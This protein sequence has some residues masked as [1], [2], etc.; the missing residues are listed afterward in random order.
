M[1]YFLISGEASGDLHASNLIRALRERDP[2]AVF[3]GM[4]GDKMREAGCN[5]FQDYRNMAYMGVIAVLSNLDKVRDNFRIAHE[6]LLREKPDVLVLID[7]PSFNLK[8]ASYCRQHLPN[9]KIVY[10]IPPKVW[11][12]KRWR[13]HKI[14]RL[15]D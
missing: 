11:A 4:G 7:Y 9:T 1:K 6:A 12:W 3:V 10:Y 2:E 8:I 14:A 13:I 5:L 15:C